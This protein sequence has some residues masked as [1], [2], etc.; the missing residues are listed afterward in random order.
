MGSDTDITVV[1]AGPTG[2]TLALQAT[3]MGASVRIIEQRPSPR[4]WAPALAVHPRTLEVLGGLGVAGELVARGVPDARLIIHFGN[5]T[6]AGRIYDLDLADTA[7]PFIHFIPQPDVESV[8]RENLA[9]AGVEV[10]WG[11]GF[12]GLLQDGERVVVDALGPT[13][14]AAISSRY[15]VGCDGAESAVRDAL[16]IP[17]RGRRYRE[18][19]VVADV[20]PRV[21]YGAGTAH[22]FMGEEG[23]LFIFPLPSGRA[24]LIA[25]LQ[26][27]ADETDVARLVEDHTRGAVELADISWVRAI[28]PQHRLARVYRRGRVFVAG[29]AAHVHSP[30]GAQGMNTGIQDAINLG[31]KLALV[32]DG[33]PADLL[34]TYESERRPVARQVVGLTGVAFALEVSEFLP[35]RIGRRWAARPIAGAILPRHKLLSRV[36]RVVSGLD[37][38]YRRGAIGDGGS[39]SGL[40]GSRLPD[41]MLEG[42]PVSRLHQ[43]IDG[44]SFH[45]L[46]VGETDEETHLTDRLGEHLRVRRLDRSWLPGDVADTLPRHVLVRPDGYIGAVT[47]DG[48]QIEEYLDKWIGPVPLRTGRPIDLP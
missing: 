38:R 35:L 15:L 10:E 30:A 6:V 44:T 11:T 3:S 16:G 26:R 40:P 20:E 13:G 8:L 41:Y 36:A 28:R 1:G 29:D 19:I 45:L 17:F 46:L 48:T 5:S 27:E 22:A 24:R 31:W 4:E 25:P 39:C 37:T 33:A 42:G 34:D 9:A 47:G 32:V 18:T 14:E 12:A 2:L 23:I 7:Y 21:G 43:M